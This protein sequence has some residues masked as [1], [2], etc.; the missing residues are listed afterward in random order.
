MT[1]ISCSFRGTPG[2]TLLHK[3]GCIYYVVVTYG[4]GGVEAFFLCSQGGEANL[5][6]CPPDVVFIS[7]NHI[8][9]ATSLIL[10]ENM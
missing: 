8:I 4:G 1:V 5:F 6:F 10:M 3:G 9:N 7:D 2:D